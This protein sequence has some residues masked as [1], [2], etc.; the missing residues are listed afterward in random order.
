V[1]KNYPQRN[2]AHRWD[3]NEIPT[4]IPTFSGV[5]SKETSDDVV[6]HN[7]KPEIQHG[8]RQTGNK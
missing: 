5:H 3:S 6:R 7:R 8:G 4:A 1:G 2:S